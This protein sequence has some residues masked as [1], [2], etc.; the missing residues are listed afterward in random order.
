MKSCL[1]YLG[2]LSLSPSS[3]FISPLPPPLSLFSFMI[4]GSQAWNLWPQF[5]LPGFPFILLHFFC[6]LVSF[7][8]FL[9]AWNIC[10]FFSSLAVWVDLGLGLCLCWNPVW[11]DPCRFWGLEKVKTYNKRQNK[12]AIKE[13]KIKSLFIHLHMRLMLVQSSKLKY[14]RY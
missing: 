9:N 4:N 12:Q 2:S 7:H 3:P 13:G 8:S 1:N 11:L 5:L 14:F 10:V 6:A